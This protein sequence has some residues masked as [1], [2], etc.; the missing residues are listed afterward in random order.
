MKKDLKT[1]IE[2]GKYKNN[3]NIASLIPYLLEGVGYSLQIDAKP[4]LRKYMA[5]AIY[6]YKQ[7][8]VDFE[9]ILEDMDIEDFSDE[10]SFSQH[11]M[12]RHV[13][14]DCAVGNTKIIDEYIKSNK[15]QKSNKDLFFVALGRLSTS[16][17]AATLLLNNGFFV[18]VVSIL[19][20]IIE[21]LAWGSFLLV[22]EDETKII[23]NRTQSN[24]R[25]LKEQLGENYGTLYGY[26]S[27]EAHLEPKEIGKYLRKDEEEQ[28]V[29][30]DRSGK[31]CEGETRTLLVLLDGYCKLLWKGMNHFGIVEEEKEYYTE[32]HNLNIDIVEA[33]ETVLENNA[34]I[35]SI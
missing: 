32:W 25:F 6:K 35:R 26:L 8:D 9:D 5:A 28:I 27:S 10:N 29:V 14:V 11:E 1:D 17:K 7:E 33:M 21:Q 18:E 3:D 30:R 22:E 4:L 20:L 16:F 31:E 19:R 2:K 34:K 13:I 23:K 15:V 24:V 12:V